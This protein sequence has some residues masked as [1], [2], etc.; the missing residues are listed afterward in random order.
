MKQ[1]CLL[2]NWSGQKILRETLVWKRCRIHDYS[3]SYIC[4]EQCILGKYQDNGA[5]HAPNC[6]NK[7]NKTLTG[8]K[9]TY[10]TNELVVHV[11]LCDSLN[12]KK[13]HILYCHFIHTQFLYI[14][15]QKFA[16]SLLAGFRP[17]CRISS[18]LI[19]LDTIMSNSNRFELLYVNGPHNL[20]QHNTETRLNWVVNQTSR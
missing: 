17:Q 5:N 13:K 19:S 20:S 14:F 8:D 11:I 9:N 1:L 3:M 2:H 12:R 7:V 10:V 18:L 4:C 15:S 16:P 6:R